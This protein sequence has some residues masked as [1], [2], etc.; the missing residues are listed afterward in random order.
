MPQ[1]SDGWD[2]I[3]TMDRQDLTIRHNYAYRQTSGDAIL[4]PQSTAAA[5]NRDGPT[6]QEVDIVVVGG[7]AAGVSVASHLGATHRVVLLEMEPHLAYHATGRSA[8]VLIE[9]YGSPLVQLLTRASAR[10]LGSPPT[11][12]ADHR[13]L[14]DRGALWVAFRDGEQDTSAAVAQLQTDAAALRIA[15]DPLT[16]EEA[17]AL[18]PILRADRIAAALFERSAM[19]IDVHGLHQA[20]V[21][22]ARSTGVDI[23]TSAAV[24]A[25]DRSDGRWCVRTTV[26]GFRAGIVVNAA[27]AW[28]DEVAGRAGLPPLGLR[29]YRRSAGLIRPPHGVDPG[30][31]PVVAS[32]GDPLYFKPDAGLLMLSPADETRAAAGDCYPDD[33]D[34]AI[35]V[36]RFEHAT[37]LRVER[38]ERSWAGLRTFSPDRDPILGFDPRAPG[39]FWIA[40]QGGTGIQTAPALAGL[41]ATAITGQTPPVWLQDVEGVAARLSP[42][43]LIGDAAADLPTPLT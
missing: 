33:M 16:A 5:A 13:L 22:R 28:A 9:T 29:A 19:D 8:A 40:G 11:G 14:V 2:A 25:L 35:A 42:A 6:C 41:C 1:D 43:R 32:L 38:V 37:T 39:L 27:G 30:S 26:G 18:V 34:V 12:F 23:R 4:M 24:T 31:W 3:F 36:S 21:R 17:V 15:L 10:F 20:Y 7:G